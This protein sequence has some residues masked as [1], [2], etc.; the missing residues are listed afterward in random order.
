MSKRSLAAGLGSLLC[1]G[2]GLALVQAQDGQAPAQLTIK[3]PAG[4]VVSVNG[5][6]VKQAG[7]VRLL[8][9]PPLPA[10]QAFSYRVT[11]RFNAGGKEETVTR[12]VQVEAGKESTVDLSGGAP[13]TAGGGEPKVREFLFTYSATVTKLKPGQEARIWL[14]YPPTN[15]EQEVKV[16]SEKFPAKAKLGAEPK[17]GNQMLYLEAKA[18]DSGTIPVAI[19]YRVKRKEVKGD[20]TS[21]EVTRKEVEEFLKADAMVP[22]GGKSL[23][24]T[25]GKKLPEDQL[26]LGK[27]L[28]DIVNDHMTYSKKGTGWGRGDS[29]WACDSRYG[30]C[31][32]FH[33][34]FIS[35]ARAK[36]IPAKFEMGFPVPAKRGKGEIGG[37]H[38][39]A[40]FKPEGKNWVPVDISEANQALAKNNKAHSDYLFGNLTEDRVSFTQGRDINL[41]PRQA[42]APLNFFIYPYVEV[43]G[44]ALPNEQVQ[45]QFSYQ[46]VN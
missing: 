9:S 18:D 29:D 4:A 27:A 16:A 8:E 39:W 26:Q 46:D 41:V 42:G 3:A 43:D 45:R 14:P 34:L 36:N 15:K 35:L 37:Y 20:S 11:A 22:V 40:R 7:P 25:E 19:T 28:Y 13:A 30:N 24:L 6:E 31:T 5:Y 33:S 38:C 32:D 12:V 1:L 2:L 21:P 17:Y 44:K 10:G 23:M